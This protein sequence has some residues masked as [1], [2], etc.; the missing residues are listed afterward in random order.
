MDKDAPLL[1]VSGAVE[2]NTLATFIV[3]IPVF[4]ITTPPEATKG[5]IH[6]APATLDVAV[7]Y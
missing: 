5:V 1:T 3:I 6:S 2:L 4:A 7:L